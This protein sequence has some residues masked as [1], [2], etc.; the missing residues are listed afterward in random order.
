MVVRI[1]TYVRCAT[2]EQVH[3]VQERSPCTLILT[4]IIAFA[5]DV[6][7]DIFNLYGEVNHISDF[8]TIA[9]ELK[10]KYNISFSQPIR[11]KKQPTK[12]I[13]QREEKDYTKFLAM[14]EQHLYETDYLTNHGL[15]SDTQRKFRCGYV[16][17][18]QYN[19]NS[20]ATSAVII[21][22]SDHS[23]IW[24]STTENIKQK[25]GNCAYS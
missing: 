18:Y 4:V 11:Q 20:Q 2:A 22:T 6:N 9:N 25:K 21:P 3:T 12:P 23:F 7:G 17:N 16:A 14:A 15:S 1:N 10:A 24:R 19:H 8:K 13:E 5:C